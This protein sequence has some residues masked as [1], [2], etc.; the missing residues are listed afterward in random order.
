[1]GF[2]GAGT[3]STSS[4]ELTLNAA[5]FGVIIPDGDG[6]VIGHTSQI[7][8]HGGTGEFQL[9]GVD[10]DDSLLTIA[11]FEAGGGSVPGPAINFL[12]SDTNTV[13]GQGAP[14]LND[15]LGAIV[16]TVSNG[17]DFL[18]RSAQIEVEA[19]ENHGASDA[20]GRMIFSTT[21]DG[22]TTL[23]ERLRIDSSGAIIVGL[24]EKGTT[25]QTGGII[26]G[27]NL[28]TVSNQAG[29]DLTIAAGAGRGT[30]LA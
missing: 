27:I 25:A 30:G 20:P 11:R 2:T 28:S 6:M 24:G 5:G 29:A 7:A 9:I 15:D 1:M 21:P 3:I 16:W 26:R 13:G 10:A 4:N 23:T 12:K 8:T 14:D 19:D 22:S 18:T 17:T